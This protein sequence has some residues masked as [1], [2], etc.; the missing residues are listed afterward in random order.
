MPGKVGRPRKYKS[1]AESRDAQR[2]QTAA[3]QAAAVVAGQE[4]GPIPPVKNP[5]RRARCADSLEAF[6]T[7]YLP[8][9]FYLTFSDDHKA[10]IAKAESAVRRGGLFAVAMPRGSGKTALA[11]SASLWAILY[12]YHKYVYF[13]GANQRAAKKSL[14][15]IKS[16]VWTPA[17]LEDFP[18]A[19]YPLRRLQRQPHR[20][21]GQTCNGEPTLTRWSMDAVVFPTIPESV[22][23]GAVFNVDGL[24]S[25]FRGADFAHPSGAMLRPSLVIPDDPQTDR[26]AKSA[27]QCEE[28]ENILAGAIL[29]LAGPDVQI[30]GIMPCTVIVR[31]DLADR[32]LDSKVHPEWNGSRHKLVYEFPANQQLWDEYREI[33]LAYDPSIPDDNKRAEAQ[34]TEFYRQNREAMDA[35]ARI[36]WNERFHKRQ[37]SAVQYAMDLRFRD[38]RA[39]AAEYQNEPLL[40]ESADPDAL[41]PLQ[42]AANINR[43]PRFIL[44]TSASHVVAFIDVQGSLLYYCVV[45]FAT[46]FTGFVLDYGTWPDQRRPYFA[47]R[48]AQI[49]LEMATGKPSLEEQLFAG[50][51][52]L[53]EQIC[54]RP[55]LSEAGAELRIERCLID[56]GFSAD[57]IREFCRRSQFAGIVGP[58]FGR[59]IGASSTPLTP[60]KP[61]E[62]ERQGLQWYIP[63]GGKHAI[64]HT[65]YDSNFW[66]SF[67]HARLSVSEGG[68]GR[69]SLFGD[70]PSLHRMIADHITSEQRVKV[71]AEKT[72]RSVDEWKLKLG[73][74]NH[75]LD[76]CVG[77]CVA[78]STLGVSLDTMP[79]TR[80]KAARPT[81][82]MTEMKK[83][84]Q[85]RKRQRG[86]KE[87]AHR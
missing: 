60:R 52:A 72:G 51:K 86:E 77:A 42:V 73:A 65:I 11:R 48:E 1:E 2:Q 21:A 71:T 74:D 82:S 85:E 9:T 53:T 16:Y 12:G 7:T 8:K 83:L 24:T 66:K 64:R 6:C 26:S 70:T 63:P 28:R 5:E 87:Q 13:I 3:S 80:P 75:L 39:F 41:T 23:S 32:I 34:A 56:A 49:T 43:L 29:G 59:G 68:K 31:D 18:E 15:A 4:T 14:E 27:S 20:C 30:S 10:V 58:S 38:E 79:A 25:G 17:L 76:C 78:A 61:A 46:D 33:Q 47:L 40:E 36:G 54:G 44:P 50:L 22:S 37:L 69:I 57:A 81:M 19:I 45:A 67:L 55:W 35:G 84:A 62:G